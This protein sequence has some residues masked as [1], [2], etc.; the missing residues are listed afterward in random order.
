MNLIKRN[1]QIGPFC[2]QFNEHT[3]DYKP[4]I[5]LPTVITLNP[6]RSVTIQTNKPP[7]SYYLRQAAGC[8]KGA[9]ESHEVAGIVT[10]KHVYEIAKIKS[11]DSCNR[12]KT[13]EEVCQSVIG[14]AHSIGIKVERS[15]DPKEYQEFLRNREVKLAEHEQKLEEIRQSKMLRL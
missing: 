11:A 6:D 1:I 10:L 12:G 13:L 2:K 7:V 14:T 8:R 5:P 3:K 4:G 15:L 9:I